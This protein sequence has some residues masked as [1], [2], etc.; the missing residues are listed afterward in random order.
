MLSEILNAI[1]ELDDEMTQRS[2]AHVTLFE[3]P[4]LTKQADADSADINKIMARYVPGQEQLWFAARPGQ[5]L[6][7]SEVSD[8]HRAVLLVQETQ[9]RFAQL[10]ANVRAVFE[11]NPANLLDAIYDPS[12]VEELTK[13]GIFEPPSAP[14]APETTASTPTPGETKTP[15]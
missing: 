11:N 1:Q 15:A 5:Y 3:G 10:P 12:R 14:Q 4:S 7:V 2:Q 9:E 6:D 13:L 8:Y